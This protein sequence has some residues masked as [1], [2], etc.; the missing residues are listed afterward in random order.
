MT[1]SPE[2]TA[3]ADRFHAQCRE[4]F[5]YYVSAIEHDMNEYA[6]KNRKPMDMTFAHNDLTRI[7]R[8]DMDAANLA[9]VMAHAVLAEIQ[10]KARGG[11]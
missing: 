7:F 2:H 4:I 5:D 9:G 1:P 8:R 11:R 3:K 10:R 6:K